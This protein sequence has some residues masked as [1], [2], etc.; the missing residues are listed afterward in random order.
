[1][2]IKDHLLLYILVF[3]SFEKFI[4]HMVVTYA[5]YVDMGE[6]RSTV[7]VDHRLLMISGFIVGIL[8][9]V[10]IPF[11]LQR[12]RSSFTVLFFLAIFDFIGEFI[13]QGTLA[14]D[15][16]VSFLVAS[17]I[18]LILIIGRKQFVDQTG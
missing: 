2:K 5:F 3:L 6:I 12:K 1:M 9:L 7:M 16:T 8:F 18:L 4:Q 13:A 17:L 14:I 11:L 10:N 15:I